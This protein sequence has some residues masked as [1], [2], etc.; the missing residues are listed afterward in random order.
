MAVADPDGGS[1]SSN[2]PPAVSGL[3]APSRT[4]AATFGDSVDAVVSGVGSGRRLAWEKTAA[5]APD[6]DGLLPWSR[7]VSCGRSA[8]EVRLKRTC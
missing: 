8:I 7:G 4:G 3:S 5:V 2:C 6:N 1:F